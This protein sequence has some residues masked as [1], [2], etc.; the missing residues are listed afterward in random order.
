MPR[1]T[2]VEAEFSFGSPNQCDRDR[3]HQSQSI[4]EGHEFAIDTGINLGSSR[5]NFVIQ[6]VKLGMNKCTDRHFIPNHQ[7]SNMNKL[8]KVHLLGGCS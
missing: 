4:P 3:Q 7:T 6:F 8:I 2:Q 5:M 1:Q